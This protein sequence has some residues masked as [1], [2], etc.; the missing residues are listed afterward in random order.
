[1][2]I[3]KHKTGRGH[4]RLMNDLTGRRFGRLTA[5]RGFRQNGATRWECRCDCGATATP[6]YTNLLHGRTLSCGC[7]VVEAATTHGLS[8]TKEYRAWRCMWDRVTR[9]TGK[10]WR[11]YGSRGVSV[12]RRW[13]KLENFIADMGLAPSPKHSLDRVYNDGSYSKSNCRWATPSEQQ[14]NKRKRRK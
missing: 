6:L 1:M 9:K 3:P 11:N 10:A 4:G 8:K 12:C 7:G 14:R 2:S 5:L 13:K